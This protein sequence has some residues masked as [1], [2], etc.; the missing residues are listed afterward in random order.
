MK[1]ESY[2]PEETAE[3]FDKLLQAALNTRPTPLK[4]IPRKSWSKKKAGA[5]KASRRSHKAAD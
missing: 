3:R 4:D 2:S 1:R 5:A